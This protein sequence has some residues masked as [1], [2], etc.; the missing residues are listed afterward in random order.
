MERAN[1][2]SF[3]IIVLV[4][5][6]SLLPW[7]EAH[8][9]EYDE[10]WTK[11]SAEAWNR[12]LASYE[13]NPA[14][15]VSHLNLH[16]DR[17]LKE[18]KHEIASNGTRRQ[19]VRANIYNGPCMAT[20]PIDR[21]WRCNP[22]WANNRF[23]L[24][25]C[26]LGFGHKAKGGKN[27]K[28]YVVNDSSD[29]DM[30]NPKVGTLRHA[31]IQKEPLWI[32]FDRSMV[33]RLNQE[34]IMESDKT[35]DA[36]GAN[37]YI[38]HGAGITIQFRKNIIIHGLRIHNIQRGSG[39]V[40]RDSTD[41]FGFRTQSDGD[42][43]SIFGSQDIWIDHVSMTKCSDGLIDAIMGSTGI[44]IS[45]GHFTD[46]DEAMLFGAS[47]SHTQDEKMQITVAFNHFGKRMV[48]RMPRCR[49]GYIHVVNNDY[50]HWNMY[51]IGGS[52]HPTIIS[53]GNRFI[54]P[55]ETTNRFAKEVTKRE[56]V[57]ESVW[58]K[59]T[60]RSQGDLFMR[61]AFF[62]QSG[63]PDYTSKHPE[64]YDLIEPA[65]AKHVEHMTKFAGSLN[66]KVG[67]AC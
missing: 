51:A 12:T 2:Y 14:K 29:N 49:F 37:V 60:W 50:T 39:G 45:N 25:D 6:V 17:V 13:P 5:A 67:E 24:A 7:S 43:I 34:L 52:M 9:L 47:D 3:L 64:L 46:H 26:G 56:Y 54:A 40:I 48:Q 44:T 10:Y 30:L 32:I 28:I 57:P 42:G 65:D 38:A 18:I 8:I 41:H 11:Q 53:Q 21:C 33:I 35:I 66:C 27:G 4:T 20:N 36:R 55:P 19:L 16:A 22:N 61:G 31:V 62:V 23:R 15:I 1:S 59:W 58:S 63:D